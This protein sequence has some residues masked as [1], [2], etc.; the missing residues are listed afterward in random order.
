MR[1]SRV[2][3]LDAHASGWRCRPPREDVLQHPFHV[4]ASAAAPSGVIVSRSAPSSSPST[5]TEAEI[6]EA[7]TGRSSIRHATSM[8]KR[9]P[10]ARPVEDNGGS[11][12]TSVNRATPCSSSGSETWRWASTRFAPPDDADAVLGH[13]HVRAARSR[14]PTGRANREP[15][16]T[17]HRASP[18][19][20]S[21]TASSTDTGS[22]SAARA[23]HHAEGAAVPAA[24]YHAP[25]DRIPVDWR[26]PPPSRP[27][28][29]TSSAVTS[30]PSSPRST[31]T[32]SAAST[33]SPSRSTC[34]PTT[35]EKR[36]RH[37]VEAELL[38]V[39]LTPTP[40][41]VALPPVHILHGS[42]DVAQ[43]HATGNLQGILSR[44]A[45]ARTRR[46]YGDPIGISDLV[47][48]QAA[49]A[50]APAVQRAPS[51]WCTSR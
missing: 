1:S 33:S 38:A 31:S 9:A 12:Q 5:T 42:V 39:A 47:E 40:A 21:A 16:I 43:H 25:K 23:H 32:T 8:V 30:S 28:R 44:A 24:S 26:P 10:T 7:F 17:D 41:S 18:P 15:A 45:Q 2:V 14:R 3:G 4:R 50:P 27:G 36:S 29:A 51:Q 11:D 6:L 20:S 13:I 35:W 37:G 46:R 34:R 19:T 49:H 22:T 48:Q